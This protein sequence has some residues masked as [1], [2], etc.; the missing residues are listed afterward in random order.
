[1]RDNYCRAAVG[2]TIIVALRGLFL[3][4]TP[5]RGTIEAAFTTDYFTMQLVEVA[6]LYQSAARGSRSHGLRSS[7]FV[8]LP[9]SFLAPS[10]DYDEICHMF[11]LRLILSFLPVF[12]VPPLLFVL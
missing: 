7:E 4:K 11:G 1:M 8:F 5:T 9:R 6:H 10:V 3:E 12:E 2:A